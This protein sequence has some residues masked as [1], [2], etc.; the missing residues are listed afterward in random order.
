[1]SVDAAT[2]ESMTYSQ[3]QR[4]QAVRW[5]H[6]TG[7]LAAEARLPAPYVTKDG[8]SAGPEHD[9][10]LPPAYAAWSLLPE[11]RELAL[12]LFDELGI[13]W[14]AG[15]DGGPSNHL[16]SSQV[17]CVNALGQM[18]LDPD[19]LQQR[20]RRPRRIEE[21][22]EIEPGRYLTFEYIGP[23]DFFDEAPRR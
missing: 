18:V 9:F 23:T 1:M 17:Q 2:V 10:C 19:R 11:V 3:A 15:V 20:L 8:S 21:V 6:S 4:A 16:L 5:K 13:P 12:E 14:H 22:L 7:T